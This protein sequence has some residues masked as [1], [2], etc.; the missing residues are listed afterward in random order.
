MDELD[1]EVPTPPADLVLAIDELAVL[2]ADAPARLRRA[3]RPQE[4]WRPGAAWTRAEMLGHLI[5]SALNNLQRFV[6]LQ[7]ERELR[8]PGYAQDDWVALGAYRTRPWAELVEEWRLLNQHVLHVL[9]RLDPAAL[10]NRW[11]DA[12]HDLAWL[13][14]DYVRHLRHHL[15]QLGATR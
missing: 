5:D 1:D 15:G 4:P 7:R 2:V 13:A 11:L 3:E 10:R 14:V 12:D 8:F 6:R 9:R